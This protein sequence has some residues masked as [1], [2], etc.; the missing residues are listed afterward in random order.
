MFLIKYS[1][2][3]EWNALDKR[4]VKVAFALTIPVEGA[5]EHLRLLSLIARKLIDDDFR[6]GVLEENNPEKLTAIINQIQF[7]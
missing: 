5:K 7:D 1:E 6:S 3:I 2:P 4:P